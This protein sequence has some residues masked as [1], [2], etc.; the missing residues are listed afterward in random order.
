MVDIGKINKILQRI[1]HKYNFDEDDK[2]DIN[3]VVESLNKFDGIQRKLKE[4]AEVT[5]TEDSYLYMEQYYKEIFNEETRLMFRG[6]ALQS[7]IT[8]KIIE[9]TLDILETDAIYDFT[10]YED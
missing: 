6:M 3:I 7:E 10:W 9:K 1:M 2:N 4:Y 8:Q 5:L